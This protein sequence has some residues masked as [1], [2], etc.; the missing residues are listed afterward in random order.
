VPAARFAV[1]LLALVIGSTAPGCGGNTPATP[2]PEFL[3]K[4]CSSDADCGGSAN[5]CLDQPGGGVACGT[6][7]SSVSCPAGYLCAS[8]AGGGRNCIPGGGLC[9][10]LGPCNGGCA[11]G[12]RCDE[13][14]NS[15]LPPG[16]AGV[17]PDGPPAHVGPWPQQD[18]DVVDLGDVGML[19]FTVAGDVR[20]ADPGG[21][22]PTTII[23]KIM[24]QMD[25]KQPAFGVFLGDYIFVSPSNTVQAN[26]QFGYFLGARRSFGPEMYYVLGNHEAYNE[27]LDAFHRLLTTANYYA[28]VGQTAKG[29]MKIIV[30][31]DNRWEPN[32]Q[33]KFVQAQLAKPTT[34]TFV[35]HHYPSYASASWEPSN[36]DVRATLANQNITLEL[37][38]HYHLY[39]QRNRVVTVGNGGAPLASSSDFYGFLLVE[40]QANGSVLGT[41]IRQ[42]TGLPVDSFTVTP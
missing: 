31:A 30:I 10:A 22:Y 23:T 1:V 15:C 34:Y 12:W 35:V 5:R 39:D 13:A 7:C 38:G 11:D 17:T 42:D 4:P 32:Y 40:L 33:K 37:A 25:A 28:L 6:D 24:Q 2:L 9:P 26:Q 18:G 21:A 14:S 36:G 8:V 29:S 19:R 41:A 20:P 16:D 3:C 27:N